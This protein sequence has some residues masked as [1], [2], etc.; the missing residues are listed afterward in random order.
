MKGKMCL[1]Y[2]TCLCYFF[3]KYLNV[4][5]FIPRGLLALMT[6]SLELEASYRCHHYILSVA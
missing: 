6:I 4:E 3:E 2:L 1:M 5:Y